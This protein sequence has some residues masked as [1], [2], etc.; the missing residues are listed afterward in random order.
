MIGGVLFAIMA[1]TYA[2]AVFQRENKSASQERALIISLL[3]IILA[4]MSFDS[5]AQTDNRWRLIQGKDSIV[6][7]PLSDL[8]IAAGLRAAKNFSARQCAWELIKR[9]Q[10]VVELRDDIAGRKSAAKIQQAVVAS[11]TEEIRT[12][13]DSLQKANQKI[14]RRNPFTPLLIGVVGGIIIHQSIQ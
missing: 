8:R 13:R 1:I 7:V 6:E 14:K 10:E 3:L 9:E 11:Q 12:L 5:K 2:I 4:M